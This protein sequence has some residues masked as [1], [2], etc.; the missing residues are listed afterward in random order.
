[1]V[2]NPLRRSERGNEVH[3]LEGEYLDC[4]PARELVWYDGLRFRQF[5][6]V[7]SI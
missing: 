1:M 6:I 5:A 2:G 7:R 4:A 3:D